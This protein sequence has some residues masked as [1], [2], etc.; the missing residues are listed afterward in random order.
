MAIVLPADATDDAI[1]Q[2]VRDW[3]AALAAGDFDGAFAMTAHEAWG[4]T[5]TLI[6]EVI[7]GYGLPEPAQDGLVHVVTPID[8]CC[9]GPSPRFR[10]RR[11]DKPKV[12]GG[13]VATIGDVH[14]D[15]PLDGEWSDL[16]AIFWIERNADGVYLVLDQIHVL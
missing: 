6:R 12:L 1:L 7:A 14:F 5:P 13:G 10:V 3:V 2:L 16:T 8:S 9:G 15:L 11:F 4:W